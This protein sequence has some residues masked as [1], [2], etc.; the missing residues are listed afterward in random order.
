MVGEGKKKE[1]GKRDRTIEKTEEEEKRVNLFKTTV[2]FS[3]IQY[4]VILA[5]TTPSTISPL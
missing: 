2:I 1:R 3:R 5:P 4:A